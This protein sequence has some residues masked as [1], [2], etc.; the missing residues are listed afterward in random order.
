[1]MDGRVKGLA[2]CNNPSV[3]HLGV[4]W[5]SWSVVIGGLCNLLTINLHYIVADTVYVQLA[6][7]FKGLCWTLTRVWAI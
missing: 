2:S 5:G 4:L 7:H 6:G 3:T 1:M